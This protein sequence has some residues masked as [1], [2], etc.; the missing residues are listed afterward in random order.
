M[1]IA[2]TS[3]NAAV[4]PRHLSLFELTIDL[5]DDSTQQYNQM[6][7]AHPKGIARTHEHLLMVC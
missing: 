1:V 4:G 5:T 7:I 2:S 6:V 3:V